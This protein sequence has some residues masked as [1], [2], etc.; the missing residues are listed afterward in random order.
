MVPKQPEAAQLQEERTWWLWRS[1]P[2]P[3]VRQE[4]NKGC[5]FTLM[6]AGMPVIPR[7]SLIQE[8]TF[9]QL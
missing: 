8:M 1:G 6:P 9:V 3:F 7:V 4:V 2:G 5:G